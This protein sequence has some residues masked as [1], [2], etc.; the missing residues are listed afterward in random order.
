MKKN[1]LAFLI[2]LIPISVNAFEKYSIT[3]YAYFDPINNKQ[4]DETN[5][6][7]FYNQDTTC[8]RFIVLE[9]NDTADQE[10]LKIMLDH[11]IASDTYNNYENVLK[12]TKEK[13]TNYQ[14]DL[15]II[16]ED[17]IVKFMKLST[18]PEI[19]AE[20][21]DAISVNNNGLTYSRFMFN[22]YYYDNKELKNYY[23]FWSKDLYPSDQTYAY[24]ITEYGNNRLVGITNK[25][26]I[27]PVLNI[28]KKQLTKSS[29]YLDYTSKITKKYS[30]P[31]PQET[32]DNFTY[33]QLQG[34][35]KTKDKLVFYSSNNSNPDRGLVISYTGADFKTLYKKSYDNT[36]HGNDMTYNSK[37]NEVLLVGPNSYQEIFSYNADTME[38]TKTYTENA[39]GYSAIAY[40]KY[41]DLYF[42]FLGRK[43][44]A[45]DSEFNKLYSFDTG[46]VETTQGMEYHDG[47]LY[48]T[49][50]E[51]GCSS[52]YQFWCLNPTFSALVYVYNAKLTSDKKTTK[53]FGRLEKIIYLGPDIGELESISF[54]DKE[55]IFGYATQAYDA[56]N[57]Y[58]FYTTSLNNLKNKPSYTIK[59]VTEE[60]SGKIVIFSEEELADIEGFTTVNKTLLEKEIK[61]TDKDFSVNVCD[62]YNNCNTEK[63]N[64]AKI[65]E[66]KQ[67]NQNNANA[68]EET[69]EPEN[70]K[71][72]AFL[73]IAVILIG[74]IIS[75][76]GLFGVKNKFK[77]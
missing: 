6:W 1:I 9:D 62:N 7:T 28:S 57:T 43:M 71:T 41:N 36:G 31:Y 38:H 67:N 16:D 13:W 68:P 17:T 46:S 29:P 44:Y 76:I 35:T 70:P 12:Q 40:D 32:Y 27:R 63:F 20:N 55:A 4:C 66:L 56:N 59:Y 39:S 60:N 30:Y 75:L 61:P 18:K 69:K 45:L 2:F 72:G 3:D 52:R 49:T 54:D 26:G 77:I 58:Q 53:S 15:D 33:K 74:G 42:G 47:Y 14:G 50:F 73:S 48:M 21:P 34:F 23:G 24:T 5:Y 37:T 64:I 10:N 51:G 19:S 22:S 11:N 65:L 25:R 8:Y